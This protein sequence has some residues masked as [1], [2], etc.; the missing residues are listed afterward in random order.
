MCVSVVS[1]SDVSEDLKHLLASLDPAAGNLDPS[2]QQ[3]LPRENLHSAQ[4]AE[5]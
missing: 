1:R 5:D 2:E 4:L 3:A